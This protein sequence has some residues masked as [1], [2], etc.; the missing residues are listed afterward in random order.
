MA[1]KKKAI[2]EKKENDNGLRWIGGALVVLV[3]LYLALSVVFDNLGKIDYN[4]LTFVK[5]QMGELTIYH[6]T[7]YF[8]NSKGVLITYNLYLRTNPRKLNVPV[9]GEIYLPK[10]E[11]VYIS[12]N[13]TENLS[14]CENSNMAAASLAGFLT[15]ND[16]IVKGA[17]PD[18][19]LAE[20]TNVSYITCENRPSATVILIQ[21]GNE[22]SIV[23][24]KNCY[25]MNIAD[26]RILEAVE[27]FETQIII[28][29]KKRMAEEEKA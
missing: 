1:R 24:D 22:T 23:K 7:Y 8:H 15:N 13:A 11:N 19:E 29:A 4:G 2:E 9:E 18:K 3:I 27:K 26:C 17:T 28:D 14:K 25:V 12:I 20:K 16:Y 10:K 5:E 6:Y 21:E